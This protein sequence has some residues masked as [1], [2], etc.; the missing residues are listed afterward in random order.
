MA[1][2][3]S[4]HG[5]WLTSAVAT[6]MQS[7]EPASVSVSPAPLNECGSLERLGREACI[8]PALFTR[9]RLSRGACASIAGQ[10]ATGVLQ[11]E[12]ESIEHGR[13]TCVESAMTLADRLRSC[14]EAL[15]ASSPHLSPD[16]RIRLEDA[17]CTLETDYVRLCDAER[18][19]FDR[20]LRHVRTGEV[21]DDPEFTIVLERVVY[22]ADQGDDDVRTSVAQ[23]VQTIAAVLVTLVRQQQ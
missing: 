6:M 4:V 21:D 11:D 16:C 14:R 2:L 8:L 9:A 20:R 13:R 19:F 22:A 3:N 18:F 15:N 23:A 17:L 5:N 12:I 1:R 10:G 7:R